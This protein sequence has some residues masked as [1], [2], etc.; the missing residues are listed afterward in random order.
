MTEIYEIDT[1]AGR[2]L[3]EADTQAKAVGFARRGIKARRLSG[4]EVRALP[5]DARVLDASQSA[6]EAAGEGDDPSDFPAEA[7]GGEG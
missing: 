3:V 5:A 6:A 1:P 4:A 7:F 2:A